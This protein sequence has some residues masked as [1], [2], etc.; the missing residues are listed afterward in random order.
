ML[1]GVAVVIGRFVYPKLSLP[2][3]SEGGKG[4]TF[5]LLMAFGLGLFAEAIG[6]HMIAPQAN[7]IRQFNPNGHF[8]AP[9]SLE[10]QGAVIAVWS[11]QCE[12][13]RRRFAGIPSLG[14]ALNND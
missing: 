5:V 2:F 8:H 11:D 1:L 4:F 12:T 3:R 10:H 9:E 14:C 7:F 6:L 13:A